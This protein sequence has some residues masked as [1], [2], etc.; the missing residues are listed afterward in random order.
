MSAEK[1]QPTEAEAALAE[2][3]KLLRQLPAWDQERLRS[4]WITTSSRE[5]FDDAWVAQDAAKAAAPPAVAAEEVVLDEMGGRTLILNVNREL[6]DAII[7]RFRAE[8]FSSN[9]QLLLFQDGDLIPLSP[10]L[11]QQLI[12]RNFITVAVRLEQGRWRQE[13]RPLITNVRELIGV[14]ETLR[15][16]CA[17]GPNTIKARALPGHNQ[18]QEIISR[19]G[20]GENRDAVGRA[21]NLTRREIDEVVRAASIVDDVV[22]K[23]AAR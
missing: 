3:T 1:K 17:R 20:T 8:L 6:I 10:T 16:R 21:Y 7:D 13:F 18:R 4:K 23:L 14:I 11:M 5:P 2:S 15:A 19:V 9:D 12:E 22:R